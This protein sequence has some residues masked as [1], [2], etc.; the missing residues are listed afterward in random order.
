MP[1][2]TP[3]P[4]EV[5]PAERLT[6]RLVRGRTLFVALSEE[7]QDLAI[8]AM[9]ALHRASARTSRQKLCL[10]GLERR[11]SERAAVPPGSPLPFPTVRP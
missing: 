4:L 8:E 5:F 9:A 1:L 2:S 3:A 10:L 6:D 11:T 7:D